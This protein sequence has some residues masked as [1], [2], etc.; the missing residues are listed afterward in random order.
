[1]RALPI[2]PT[3]A[4]MSKLTNPLRN[5]IGDRVG[6][7]VQASAYHDHRRHNWIIGE[8]M[9][10]VLFGRQNPR[11]ARQGHRTCGSSGAAG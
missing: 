1:M 8:E 10:D 4:R 3:G 9:G 6:A 7:G 5:A 2:A 11:L